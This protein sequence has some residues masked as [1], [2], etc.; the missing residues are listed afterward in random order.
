MRPICQRP[1]SPS[2]LRVEAVKGTTSEGVHSSS[3]AS[4]DND[5]YNGFVI[6]FGHKDGGMPAFV[7]Q[8]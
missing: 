5:G 7:K 6:A 2:N 1:V 8:W 4:A 3:C